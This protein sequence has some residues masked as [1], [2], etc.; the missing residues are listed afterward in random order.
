[1]L[2]RN[3]AKKSTWL[4]SWHNCALQNFTTQ[5]NTTGI[6]SAEEITKQKNKIENI[7]KELAV[8]Q[9]YK[10]AKAFQT[11]RKYTQSNELL[12]RVLDIFETSQLQNSDP[13][14]FLLQKLAQNEI[15]LN[16]VQK[17]D[18]Y[19][20][21]AITNT[22]F[23]KKE[24]LIDGNFQNLFLLYLKTDLEKALNIS[25]K[26][27]TSLQEK[28]ASIQEQSKI[29]FYLGTA[30]LL[31]GFYE[32]AIQNF[33]QCVENIPQSSLK[34]SAL[35]N[36]ALTLWWK[37]PNPEKESV[38][39][40]VSLFKESVLNNENPSELDEARRKDFD[41]LFRNQ[42]LLPNDYAKFVSDEQVLVNNK[43]SITP[44]FN[45]ADLLFNLGPQTK[46]ETA[47][48]IRYAMK[49]TEKNDPENINR[50]LLLLAKF[51]GSSKQF[52]RAEGLF[53]RVLELSENITETK[54]NCLKA[55]AETL[56]TITNRKN[57]GDN[58]LEEA[59]NL[60]KQIPSWTLKLDHLSLPEIHL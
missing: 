35:N 5:G 16:N 44:L 17:A 4:K 26:A 22:D 52:I 41:E 51:Y 32:E 3:L 34:G 10:E 7:E 54:F 48:W 38:S 59:R 60:E 33:N 37:T 25:K 19:L 36:L 53:R 42:T 47:F 13:Y 23:S 14:I 2:L 49:V 9:E 39:E 57:E 46:N 45:I 18:T 12:Q 11:Q 15:S 29:L 50:V 56:Q 8:F 31:S 55:Y 6:F 1:M 24:N 20:Q 21:K 27:L 40:I 28:G 43:E 30:N 58:M